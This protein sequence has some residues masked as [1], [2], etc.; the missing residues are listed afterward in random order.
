MAVSDGYPSD[1]D[2]SLKVFL[3]VLIRDFRD[4]G[5]E[6]TVVAPQKLF[7]LAERRIPLKLPPR[8]AAYDA[9]RVLRPRYAS[10]SSKRLPLWGST[11]RWTIRSFVGAVLRAYGSIPAAPRLCYGHFLLTGGLGALRLAERFDVPAVVALGES[12][13]DAYESHFGLETVTNLLARFHK[14]I[15]V[16]YEI[17][18]RCLMRYRV[19]RSKIRVFP[20]AADKSLFYPRDK[21]KMRKKLG[22][23]L[24]CP[25]IIFVGRFTDN[26]G[27][28]RVM[29]AIRSRRDI[30][31]VF[32]GSG[33][34]H[35]KGPQVLAAKRVPHDRVPEWL[36][37]AD[38]YVQPVFSEGSS[39]SMKEAMACGLPIVSSDIAANR[40]F[41]DPSMSILVNPGSV[42]EIR[43]AI[44]RLVD[45][46]QMRS[47]MGASALK[48]A[49]S[50]SARDRARGILSW[51]E[52]A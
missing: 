49:Q 35:P 15:P 9:I 36:A 18:Y 8:D 46:P 34:M 25:I 45:D 38:V 24:A 39:N 50:F 3:H 48:H 40:E 22:L 4:L 26:K 37:A 1:A 20:N 31:A 23:P 47:S 17:E 14:I 51:L 16:S 11:Y 29:Q 43:D 5:L 52:L 10:F 42:D 28:S 7:S 32:L 41:L 19:A 2:P 27:S 33:P 13:F 30:R 21:E 44:L 12:S 6:A